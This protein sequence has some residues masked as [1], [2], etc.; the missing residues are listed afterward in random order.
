MKTHSIL[1]T[2][3][4]IVLIVLASCEKV[5]EFDIDDTQPKIVVMAQGNSDSLLS[6][7]LT[8]SRFF[9]D[10]N[11]FKVIDNATVSIVDNGTPWANAAYNDGRYYFS[12]SPRCGDSLKLTVAVPGKPDVTAACRVPYPPQASLTVNEQTG[13]YESG[14][15]LHLRLN[16]PPNEHNYYRLS[17]LSSYFWVE[18]DTAGNYDTIYTSTTHHFECSD[19]AII[20][21]TDIADLLDG[22]GT[23]SGSQLFFSDDHIN[24]QNHDI[25]LK[26][27]HY[28]GDMNNYVLVLEAFPRDLYLYERSLMQSRDDM[29][30]FS[31]P[32]QIH[33]N[34][35]KGAIGIFGIKSC[36]YLPFE[37]TPI[38]RNYDE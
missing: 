14:V 2:L 38:G 13:D 21:Q 18:R 8:Y 28:Y 15:V 34:V 36:K 7:R 31:E 1:L 3:S 19:Y 11:D 17:L 30:F 6:V 20:D 16:D 23:F 37:V 9:L 22:E 29:Q 24:G 32:T 4:A 33:C 35:S 26:F 10:A 25:T 5:V 12:E 27:N